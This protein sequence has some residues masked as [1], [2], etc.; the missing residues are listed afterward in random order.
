MK[1]AFVFLLLLTVSCSAD[2]QTRRVQSALSE[3]GFY[4][5]TADGKM[6]DET[7]AALRRFQIRNGLDVSGE[8]SP[9][10][11]A[12]LKIQDGSGPAPATQDE[13]QV[14][15]SAPAPSE[16]SGQEAAPAS[17]E[18]RAVAPAEVAPVD[19]YAAPIVATR[20]PVHDF[21][22]GTDLAEADSSEQSAAIESAQ[23]KL[24]GLGYF[25]SAPDG[26]PGPETE[27]ALLRF[28]HANHLRLTGRLDADTRA[29][30][31]EAA[32]GV[33][34]KSFRRQENRPPGVVLRGVWVH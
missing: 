34:A 23:S 13:A 5:G 12:A 26:L 30:L 8:P 4:F 11:L 20:S 27:T 33:P 17:N 14:A 16:T 19:D 1:K 29:A 24:V 32:P 25:R 6:G 28:Q 18:S 31:A 10:T 9:E 3:A 21:F 15:A 22:G 7:R 2:D